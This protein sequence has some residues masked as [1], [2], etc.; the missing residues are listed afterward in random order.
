MSETILYQLSKED[1]ELWSLFTQDIELLEQEGLEESF[2]DLLDES[3]T[4]TSSPKQKITYKKKSPTKPSHKK[5]YDSRTK[6]RLDKGQLTIERVL[7]LHGSYQKEARDQVISFLQSSYQSGMR[8]VLIITGKGRFS[9]EGVSVLKQS[10]PTW[11][12]QPP[13]NEIVLS[14]RQAHQKD[15]GSGALYILLKKNT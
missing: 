10:L 15:G 14:Y 3:N 6:E 13:L 2:A 8:V 9:P 7:D 11:I 5:T 4:Q 12:K 1:Q